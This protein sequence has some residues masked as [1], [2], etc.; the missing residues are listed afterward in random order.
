VGG[1][2]TLAMWDPTVKTRKWKTSAFD[3]EIV[4]IDFSRGGNY[5][6]MAISST[7]EENDGGKGDYHRQ[8]W[9]KDLN[10]S[11]TGCKK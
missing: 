3:D 10:E 9:V 7:K 11:L 8:I 5:L 4:A 6:A 2:G 1:D